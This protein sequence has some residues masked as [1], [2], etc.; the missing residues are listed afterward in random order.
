MSREFKEHLIVFFILVAAWVGLAALG[1]HWDRLASAAQP[2]PAVPR[3]RIPHCQLAVLRRWTIT[4]YSYRYQTVACPN[5][6][7][8]AAANRP[9]YVTIERRY[10]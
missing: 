2:L 6:G 10:K 1:T 3:P 5:M 8:Y 4:G 9:Y 7:D